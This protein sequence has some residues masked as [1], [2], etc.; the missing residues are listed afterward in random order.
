MTYASKTFCLDNL[1][2]LR[3]KVTKISP[4]CLKN[5]CE[6][7]QWCADNR[8]KVCVIKSVALAMVTVTGFHLRIC[9][10]VF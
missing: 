1:K 2:I 5:F 7:P 8:M 4:I 10:T 6:F 3:P 9:Q